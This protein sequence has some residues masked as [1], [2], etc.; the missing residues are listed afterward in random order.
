VDYIYK[1]LTRPDVVPAEAPEQQIRVRD[2]RRCNYQM[3][4]HSR[5]GGIAGLLELL[6]DKAGATTSNRLAMI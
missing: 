5:P 3:L 6:L 1:V 2:Q 4:P